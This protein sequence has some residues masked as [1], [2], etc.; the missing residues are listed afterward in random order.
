MQHEFGDTYAH[1]QA[2]AERKGRDPRVAKYVAMLEDGTAAAGVDA[3]REWSAADLDADAVGGLGSS[4]ERMWASY[5]T[6]ERSSYP[7]GAEVSAGYDLPSWCACL[8]D[9][10]RPEP[11]RVAGCVQGKAGA[12]ALSRSDR[13]GHSHRLSPAQGQGRVGSHRRCTVPSH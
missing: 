12:N 10:Q 1:E 2:I 6:A 13:L 5:L 8:R 4:D 7:G 9:W 11:R 3:G